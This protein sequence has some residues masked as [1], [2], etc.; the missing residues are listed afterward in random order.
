M[1]LERQH[2][3]GLS[4]AEVKELG[5]PYDLCIIG[6]GAERHVE[7]KGSTTRTPVVE[8]TVNEVMHANN[9][10]PT[11]LF[12]VDEIAVDRL[13]DGRYEGRGGTIRK[14][15]DWKPDARALAPTRYC[16]SLPES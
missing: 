7:V 16:N 1:Q 12:V 14:W 10:H 3:L 4:A 8:L 11:D 13:S 5:K 15:P 2:Y 9:H 6:L